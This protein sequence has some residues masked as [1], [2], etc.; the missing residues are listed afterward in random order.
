MAFVGQASTQAQHSMQSATR[1]AFDL[2]STSS[3]TLVG[4][5]FT[6]SPSP[7]HLSSSI[8]IVT[9]ASY[10]FTAMVFLSPKSG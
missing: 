1:V 2:P 4:H 9:V 5:T 7:V 6:H 10:F 3:K 8:S